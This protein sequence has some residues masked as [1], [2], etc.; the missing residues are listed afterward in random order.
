MVSPLLLLL[1]LLSFRESFENLISAGVN[2][3]TT[4]ARFSAAGAG[5]AAGGAAVI[6]VLYL[7][8]FVLIFGE[9]PPSPVLYFPHCWAILSI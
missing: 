8:C 3:N 5:G 9:D 6:C 1:L 4:C 2:Q 7:N